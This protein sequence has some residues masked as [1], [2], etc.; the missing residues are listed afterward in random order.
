MEAGSVR[1]GPV[2]SH[3]HPRGTIIT[4]RVLF[5][6]DDV[7]IRWSR[8]DVLETRGLASMFEIVDMMS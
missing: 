6:E 8:E 4:A 5:V 2:R 3:F 7:G 1:V